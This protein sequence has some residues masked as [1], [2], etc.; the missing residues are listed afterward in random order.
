MHKVAMAL[1]GILLSVGCLRAQKTTATDSTQLDYADVMRRLVNYRV[2]VLSETLRYDWC[3]IPEAW[4]SAGVLVGST[5]VTSLSVAIKRSECG[6]HLTRDVSNGGINQ[7]QT[8]TNHGDSVLV[9]ASVKRVLNTLREEYVL[10]RS[11]GGAWIVGVYR[12]TMVVSNR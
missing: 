2:S 9:V 8:I 3:R 4:D 12:I 1:V 11:K 6:N 7:M 5:E 10:R